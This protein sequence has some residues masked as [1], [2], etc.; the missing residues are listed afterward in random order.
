MPSEPTAMETQTVNPDRYGDNTLSSASS[1]WRAAIDDQRT[2]WLAAVISDGG[3]QA[4]L[5]QSSVLVIG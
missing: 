4:R 1:P 3:C 2:T 5:S